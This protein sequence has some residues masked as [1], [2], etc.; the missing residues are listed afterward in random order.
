MNRRFRSGDGGEI[1]GIPWRI[2]T[3]M[4]SEDDLRMDIQVGEKWVAVKMDLGFLMADFFYENENVLYPPSQGFRGGQMY[5]DF[6]RGAAYMG[7][8]HASETL[9][10]QRRRKKAA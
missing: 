1:G 9:S 5:L 4:K 6:C 7:W 3:G 8:T 2:V 10:D